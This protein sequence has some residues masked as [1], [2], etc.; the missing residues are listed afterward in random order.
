MVTLLFK[1]MASGETI[2]F[3]YSKPAL[4]SRLPV[5]RPSI[6][7]FQAAKGASERVD[8]VVNKVL[9]YIIS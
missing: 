5:R 4:Q 6:L 7:V 2:S 3:D 8:L 9:W 1:H